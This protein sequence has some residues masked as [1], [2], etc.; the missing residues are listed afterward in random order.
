MN[1][2]LREKKAIFLDLDGVIYAGSKLIPGSDRAVQRLI[3]C[4]YEVRFLS[5][6]SLK[7]PSS[8][9]LKL[10][11]LGIECKLGSV[12]T[13]GW[14][15]CRNLRSQAKSGMRIFV[16]G[17]KELKE[18]VQEQGLLL[19]ETSDADAVLVGMTPDFT[20]QD[21]VLASRAILAGAHFFACNEDGMY[22]GEER[23]LFPGCGAM[24]GAISGA[25]K[26]P[27]DISFGKPRAEMLEEAARQGG[28]NI[29]ECLMIGDTWSS[30]VLMAEAAQM[31]WAYV[32]T[33]NVHCPPD[34][35]YDNLASV[36]ESSGIQPA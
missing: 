18:M 12:L 10:E 28:W 21:I 13:S 15:A 6:N 23:L 9:A 3:Q 27:P 1:R 8:I 17:T 20:Y 4:G 26:K 11:Q 34:F 30:D 32:G 2:L 19:S 5:N 35:R 25:V 36:V 14:L 22:M 33:E 31:D 24:V 7:K 29:R 16:I